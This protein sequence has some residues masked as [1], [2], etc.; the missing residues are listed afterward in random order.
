MKNNKNLLRLQ[1]S[2]MVLYG[3]ITVAA[4]GF[5]SR[6]VLW[7]YLLPAVLSFFVLISCVSQD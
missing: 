4:L 3:C 2:T 5:K 1:I 7:W 6:G